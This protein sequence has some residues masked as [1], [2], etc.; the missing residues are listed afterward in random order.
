MQSTVKNSTAAVSDFVIKDLS[1]LAWVLDELRKS[2][3]G[4][5]KALK[6]FGWDA[7]MARGSDLAAIDASQLRIVRQQFHQAVGALEM[8]ELAEPA[9]VLRAM[10]AAVQKFV[11]QPELCNQGAIATIEYASF[12]LTEYLVG[13]LAD[14]PVSA[15]S[16]FPQYRDVQELV[17]AVRIHPADLWSF[18]WRWLEPQ[19]CVKTEARHYD[20]EARTILDQ[21]VLQLMKGKAPL[22][23]QSLRDLALGFSA[24]QTE[25]QPRIFWLIAA[26]Y[27]EAIAHDLLD[28]DIYVKRAA[29]RILLQYASLCKHDT[30]ISER[31]VLDLLFFC[32]QAV[33]ARA[34]NTPVLSAVRVAYGLT[35]FKPV[36][37]ELVQFG[38]FDPALLAQARKRIV[39]AKEAWSLLCAGEITKI[40]LV[41]DQFSLVTDSLRKLHAPSE[42]L[43]QALTQAIEMT[44]RTGQ[45]PAI[46]WK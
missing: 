8:V 26:G 12:A 31:L 23:A 38:R 9:L 41:A 39:S 27:F 24:N 6:R 29:S 3:E 16:L 2:L 22:A 17:R 43:A 28:S 30:S 19:L 37:Y 34:S 13:V 15:V 36:N 18:E 4:A 21:S 35:Q 44:V 11:Q 46:Q 5:A 25:Q 33:S 1:P 32:T 45:A 10:E 42:S 40:K 14:K 20:A 7:E